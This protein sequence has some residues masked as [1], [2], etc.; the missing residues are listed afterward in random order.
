M[1]SSWLLGAALVCLAGCGA[2]GG[3]PRTARGGGANASSFEPKG[4]RSPASEGRLASSAP[5][6][7][8]AD[9]LS[10]PALRGETSS[11]PPA[12]AASPESMEERPGL[13]T[14]WGEQR[15]SH[16]HDVP[17]E[18]ADEDHPFA[19]AML[20]YNDRA[21]V[22]ALAAFHGPEAGYLRETP[23]AGGAI[24]VSLLGE[25]GRPLEAIQTG[26]RTYVMGQAG[27]RY[28]IVLTNHT[29]HRFE[30]VAT[31]DGL[32]VLT[33]EAGA[34]HGRGYLLMPYQRLEIE[35]FRQ[36]SDVVAAFRFSKVADSYAAKTGQARNVGVIGVAFFDERGD[37]PVV[38]THEELRRR[39]TAIPFP[40]SGPKYARPPAW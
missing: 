4:G 13:G 31:V 38:W 14:E 33:G 35:G 20:H 29:D 28:E 7:A 24:T 12:P 2:D 1:K 11:T 3:V 15:V 40:A 37:S 16:V 21:G 30:A 17:F 8:E 19:V 10:P 32:D 23:A 36:S 27:S 22:Q 6:E 18:R 26:D 9:V 5:R 39:D 34:V 25:D